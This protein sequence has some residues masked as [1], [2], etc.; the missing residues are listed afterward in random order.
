MQDL[1]FRAGHPF[2]LINL[3]EDRQSWRSLLRAVRH[4]LGCFW[5]ITCVSLSYAIAQQHSADFELSAGKHREAIGNSQVS[6]LDRAKYTC[7]TKVFCM[8]PPRFRVQNITLSLPEQALLLRHFEQCILRVT[9]ALRFDEALQASAVTFFK[10]YY[11][12]NAF[13]AG[14][15]FDIA[16]VISHLPCFG[17]VR[18]THQRRPCA[19]LQPLHLPSKQRHVRTTRCRSS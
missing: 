6:I 14:A 19:A 2:P 16:Y 8:L 11:V 17:S 3:K 12:H 15:P 4:H 5:Q 7:T 9:A 1:S 18:P 10:R 13:N